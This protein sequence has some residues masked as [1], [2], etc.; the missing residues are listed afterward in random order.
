[1]DWSL[2]DIFEYTPTE[3]LSNEKLS[4]L[5]M[6]YIQCNFADYEDEFFKSINSITVPN[7]DDSDNYA[8]WSYLQAIA[9]RTEGNI[10]S[11]N[12]FLHNAQKSTSNTFIDEICQEALGTN[13]FL[14]GRIHASFDILKSL[15]LRPNLHPFARKMMS[16]S[17]SAILF[18]LG[19]YK[20]IQSTVDKSTQLRC[21]I[22]SQLL[23][24]NFQYL[25]TQLEDRSDLHQLFITSQ[26]KTIV[27]FDIVIGLAIHFKPSEYQ[28]PSWLSDEILKYSNSAFYRR[29]AM[30]LE[31]IPYKRE[32]KYVSEIWMI[33]IREA[34]LDVLLAMRFE[35]EEVIH[36]SLI[37][38]YLPLAEKYRLNNIFLPYPLYNF[39]V[40][41]NPFGSFFNKFFS[42][43]DV[44]TGTEKIIISGGVLSYTNQKQV[45]HQCDFSN[46]PKTL[47]LLFL[48]LGPKGRS[49]SNEQIFD[50]LYSGDYDALEHGKKIYKLFERLEKKLESSG[51]PTF[52]ERNGTGQ[53]TTTFDLISIN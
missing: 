23:A 13:Y 16:S 31:L 10:D 26:P 33:H 42:S 9:A 36:E 18:E 35:Q 45:L 15:E 8:K 51:F 52:W 19:Q 7:A 34:F 47:S 40:P 11:S 28:L 32:I 41:E 24:G 2:I 12:E 43:L 14:Q 39:W 6:A 49:I 44:N 30:I 50:A 27:L 48:M 46:A 25:L 4:S 29:I 53:V 1:M 5:D 20:M 21:E 22:H 37:N 38:V 3:L 17:L